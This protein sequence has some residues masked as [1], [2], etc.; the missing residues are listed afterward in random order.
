MEASAARR[1][2]APAKRSAFLSSTAIL[3]NDIRTYEQQY[4]L[5]NV[6]LQNVLVDGAPG[7]IQGGAQDEDHARYRAT[8]SALYLKPMRLSCTRALS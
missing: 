1:S 8:S 5:P 7:G 4:G 6:P 2:M 3:Q